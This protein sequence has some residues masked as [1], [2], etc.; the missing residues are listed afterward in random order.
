MLKTWKCCSLKQV[1][2][3]KGIRTRLRTNFAF[4]NQYRKSKSCNRS[5]P[6]LSLGKFNESY[7]HPSVFKTSS[8]QFSIIVSSVEMI[9]MLRN[10]ACYNTLAKCWFSAWT[11]K[12]KRNYTSLQRFTCIW[13]LSVQKFKALL[14]SFHR[15]VSKDLPNEL[16]RP[17][18][19]VIKTR[20]PQWL[21]RLW[22]C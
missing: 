16:S 8:P 7:Q 2:E 20:S 4:G 22:N 14:N 19:W 9:L 11:W 13:V 1:K 5:K 10:M 6:I 3:D 15:I 12:W 17:G 18:V 21:Q